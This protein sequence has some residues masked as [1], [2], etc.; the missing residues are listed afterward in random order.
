MTFQDLYAPCGRDFFTD[1]L[2]MQNERLPCRLV[3][4]PHGS[5]LPR[6]DWVPREAVPRTPPLSASFKS[7]VSRVE[8]DV[9]LY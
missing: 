9:K 6:C 8:W 2:P 3:E 4:I 1:L 7:L 5:S